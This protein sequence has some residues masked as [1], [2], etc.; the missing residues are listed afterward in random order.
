MIF[1]RIE[2][3]VVKNCSFH[4]V[5]CLVTDVDCL[6]PLALYTKNK[7][8]CEH[9]GSSG[10][11][12]VHTLRICLSRCACVCN[13]VW[14]SIRQRDA[15]SILLNFV[16]FVYSIFTCV[17]QSYMAINNCGILLFLF[18]FF[19]FKCTKHD[20]A[21]PIKQIAWDGHRMC[22]FL[23]YF[24]SCSIISWGYFGFIHWTIRPIHFY[25]FTVCHSQC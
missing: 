1:Y 5:R 11:F 19:F 15:N 24:Q 6:I 8:P 14:A 4:F 10:G 2:L 12:L 20:A 13:C 18:F 3:K 23:N 21:K 25:L 17:F 7:V 9:N 16:I 22:V